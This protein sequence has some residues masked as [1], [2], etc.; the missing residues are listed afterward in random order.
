M[1][2][3]VVP[4]YNVRKY[5]KD[6]VE[7][8]Y[9]QTFG[10]FELLL[11]DDASMDGSGRLA[12][13]LAAKDA[14][15]RVIHLEKNG[16]QGPARNRG[17]RESIGKYIAFIDSDDWVKKDY[18]ASLVTAAER[19]R[20]DV[21]CMG[22][23][24]YFPEEDGSWQVEPH[25]HLVEQ[26]AMLTPDKKGRI[27]AVMA[28][29][30]PNMAYGKLIARELFVAAGLQFEPILSEDTLF[31]FELLERAGIYVLIPAV[32]YCYRQSP[33]S[34]LHGKSLVKSR[35]AMESTLAALTCLERDLRSMPE[36]RDDPV[37]CHRVR[38]WFAA[39]YLRWLWLRVSE[40]L[41]GN[42]VLAE[43]EQVFLEK[44]PEQAA[45]LSLLLESWTRMFVK[46]DA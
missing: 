29:R 19:Y 42:A 36:L 25:W 32:S 24:R 40:G 43:A 35:K 16:G 44:A 28:G 18:L 4:V 9:A 1:V 37:L 41:D 39:V 6:C 23:E 27:E 2:S 20:A 33:T 11:I 12:D 15:A 17:I 14:R 10:D 5:L 22:D 38:Q 3:V 8:V 46:T 34:T 7:S 26:D 31:A 13:E 30:L 45:L 21:V